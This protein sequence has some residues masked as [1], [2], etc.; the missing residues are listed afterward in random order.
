MTGGER[1]GGVHPGGPTRATMM[2]RLVARDLD[3]IS[4][5]RNVPSSSESPCPGSSKEPSKTPV[6][7]LPS[8]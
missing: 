8:W 1:G 4:M 5:G 2:A 6:A 7:P 3:G